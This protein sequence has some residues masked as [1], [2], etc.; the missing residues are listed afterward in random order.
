MQ[1]GPVYNHLSY[2]QDRPVN[3]KKT[4]DHPVNSKKKHKYIICRTVLHITTWII[5]RT[6]TYNEP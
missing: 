1:D 5:C 6:V 2:M 3:C 4:L